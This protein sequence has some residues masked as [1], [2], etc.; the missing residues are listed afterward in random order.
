MKFHHIPVALS[1]SALSLF[2]FAVGGMAL[3]IEHA[4]YEQAAQERQ[5][6]RIENARKEQMVDSLKVTNR[7]L[8][9][10]DVRWL[11]RALY[12]ETRNPLEMYY[13]GWVI[14]NRVELRFRGETTYKEVVLDPY[15]FSGFNPNRQ[16]RYKYINLDVTDLRDPV[17]REKWHS[18]LRTAID[19]IDA[20]PKDR[21]F[22]QNTLYF[23][24]EISM[25]NGRKPHWEND[26]HRVHVPGVQKVRFRFYAD[27]TQEHSTETTTTLVAR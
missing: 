3:N 21:P 5:E 9:D 4:K 14:R 20:D 23:Y 2:M 6:L 22:T 10:E 7:A 12:S 26:L 24:S 13:V 16:S 27:F 25:P 18:A 8:H 19:V 15:Q 1:I 17:R 11:A